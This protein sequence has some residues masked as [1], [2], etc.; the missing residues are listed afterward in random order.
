MR[1]IP[2]VP[3]INDSDQILQNRLDFGLV[4]SIVNIDIVDMLAAIVIVENNLYGFFNFRFLDKFVHK[5]NLLK[6]Y[7]GV[8]FDKLSELV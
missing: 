1:T 2:E 5:S 6:E 3:W 7:Y 8:Y 4:G